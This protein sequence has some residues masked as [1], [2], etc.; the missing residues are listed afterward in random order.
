MDRAVAV[1]IEARL[2]V[3]CAFPVPIEGRRT[4]AALSDRFDAARCM[5]QRVDTGIAHGF[6]SRKMNL[7]LSTPPTAASHVAVEVARFS[8]WPRGRERC[9]GRLLG[10]R[11]LELRQH[12]LEPLHPG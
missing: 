7:N 9:D 3:Q 6:L 12:S 2:T 11:G 5:L 8:A 4:G 10:R 1:I